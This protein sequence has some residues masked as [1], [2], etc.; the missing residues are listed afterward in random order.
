MD[1]L[2]Y[3]CTLLPFS[4]LQGSFPLI[5]F[6]SFRVNIARLSGQLSFEQEL[7][8]QLNNTCKHGSNISVLESTMDASIQDII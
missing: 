6:A 8:A 5:Y 3:P 4:I 2:I 7:F 1:V